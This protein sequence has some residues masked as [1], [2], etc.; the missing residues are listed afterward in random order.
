MRAPEVR[1]WKPHPTGPGH[2][3]VGEVWVYEGF[4]SPELGNRRDILVYLPPSYP[5]GARRYPVLYM[6]DGQNLFDQ[7]TSYVGEWRVDESM[8]ALAQESL[9]AIVVGIPNM[10]LERLGEYSPFRDPQHGGGRGDRYLRFVVET[11]KP[12][13][14]REFRTLPAREHTAIAGSSMGGFISLCAYYLYPQVFG[15]AGVMSPSFWFAEGAIYG[16]VES[17]PQAPG[18]LYMD[19]G[20]L[21]QTPFGGDARR[22][23]EDVRRMHRLLLRKGW[24]PGVDYLYLEDEGGAHH[25]AHWARRFPGMVRFLLGQ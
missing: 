3:V 16:L 22:Y 13:I 10:G 9:E 21:E 19:V 23:L 8:E 2:S 12:F 11:L 7:A 14:D 4:Y 20:H 24:R 6:H 18:R 5:H 17:A 25:E 1:S 15:R